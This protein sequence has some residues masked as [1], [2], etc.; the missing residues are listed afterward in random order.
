MKFDLDDAYKQWLA[1]N[2]LPAEAASQGHPNPPLFLP[3]P[4]MLTAEWVLNRLGFPGSYPY[5]RGVQ[6]TMY[7]GRR[8]TMRQYAGFGT[9]E[10]TN[11]R[12]RYLLAQGTS[13]LSV[14]FDLP[15]Q[16]GRDSDHPLAVGEVGR[17]GVAINSIEDMERLFKDIPL[18]LVSTSMTINSTAHILLAFYLEVAS[19]RAIDWKSL[20]GTVQNDV[21]KEYIARGTYIYPP[22]GALRITTDIM[23]FCA[24]NVP[25]WNTISVSG[26][27]VREAGCTAVEELAISIANGITYLTAA[28]ARGLDVDKIAPRV[29]FFFNA[30]NNFLEEVAKFRAARR[31]WARVVRERFGAKNERSWM[32]RF[33]T[34][35]AGSTLTAQQP[36]N[37]VVRTT[38]QALSAVMGGTQ[39]LHTNSYD[40]ALSLPTEESATVA[41]RTQQIIAEESGV[42]EVIDPFG[43]SYAVESL[44]DSIQAAAEEKIAEIEFHGGMLRAIEL[45]LPQRWIGDAAYSYQKA[46]ESN[47]CKV[48]GVNCY[49]DFGS[50]EVGTSQV[51]TSQGGQLHQ[52]SSHDAQFERSQIESLN[53]LKS[54]R[55]TVDC[56][57]SLEALRTSVINGQNIMPHVCEAAKRLAT[58]GEISDVLRDIYGEF[59]PS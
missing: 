58:L 54:R 55:S 50:S 13:G 26:Y 40:E 28:C 48:V 27:H 6:P 5:T 2:A 29:A 14:A 41:L 37:N 3:T 42:S 32:L 51:G 53:S 17:V 38:L 46:L 56:Q 8:W 21:L 23:E 39:S 44:T 12:Y 36:L 33:H 18:D 49:A 1:N 25:E 59:R 10:K 34:Q 11:E 24:K 4:D 31:I 52:G 35:T 57:S 30:H 20:R 45:G 47:Q 19:L 22:T 7:R 43:G 9:P 15:T 16:M